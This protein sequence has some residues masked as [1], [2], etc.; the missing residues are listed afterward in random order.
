MFRMI[1]R[2]LS[3]FNT[4]VLARLLPDFCPSSERARSTGAQ[5]RA[6]L[7]A[8][9]TQTEQADRRQ[10]PTHHR[11][12]DKQRARRTKQGEGWEVIAVGVDPS[13]HAEQV[14]P[15][16]SPPPFENVGRRAHARAR[17]GADAR[18]Q[19]RRAHTP[20]VDASCRNLQSSS[21]TMGR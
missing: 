12:V 1:C 5:S 17:E 2:K 7:E 3:P 11:N 15:G 21:G 18:A 16:G 8:P 20:A 4:E 9:H 13:V 10:A 6:G 14:R 19:R